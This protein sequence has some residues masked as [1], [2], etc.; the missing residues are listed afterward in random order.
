[1]PD[2]EHSGADV[3]HALLQLPQCVARVTSVSQP[4]AGFPLQS[5]CPAAQD[6]AGKLHMPALQD[7]GPITL[8]SAV[9]SFPQVPQLCASL[10]T[11][12]PAQ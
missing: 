8:L 6:D 11:Q 3:V 12:A 7:T 10:G 1:M 2:P 4:S 9:Q 5:A